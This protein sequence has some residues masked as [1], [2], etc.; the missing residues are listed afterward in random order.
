MAQ[1]H[2]RRTHRQRFPNTSQ[3]DVLAFW[4]QK[5]YCLRV[6]QAFWAIR[7]G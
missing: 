4:Q 7:F 6:Y 1:C 2:K 3:M 5:E